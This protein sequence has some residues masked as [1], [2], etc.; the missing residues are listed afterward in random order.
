MIVEGPVK[1]GGTNAPPQ[2]PKP[3]FRPPGQKPTPNYMTPEEALECARKIPEIIAKTCEGLPPAVIVVM[4][5]EEMQRLVEVMKNT[6]NQ[7]R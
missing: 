1:K 6:D 5:A 7:R 3:S 2:S 4:I